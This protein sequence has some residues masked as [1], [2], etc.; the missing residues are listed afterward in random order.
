MSTSS[1]AARSLLL[2]EIA[3]IF[4]VAAAGERG[5][6]GGAVASAGFHILRQ[7]RGCAEGV[8][9]KTAQDAG[10]IR[11][12]ADPEQGKPLVIMMRTDWPRSTSP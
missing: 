5:R 4:A 3:P 10:A 1:Y 8:D 2:A 12:L 6:A 11:E 9:V 7:S